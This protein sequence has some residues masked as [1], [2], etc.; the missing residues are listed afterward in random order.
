MTSQTAPFA[1]QVWD[2]A[3]DVGNSAPKIADVVMEASF[4]LTCDQARHEGA[5]KMLR[6]G[7]I[8]EV[9]RILRDRDDR[10]DQRDFGETIQQFA[11]LIQGLKS[12]SYFAPSAEEYVAVRDLIA[13][14]D[15]LNDARRFMR[16][17]GMECLAEADRLDALYAA[18]TG[19]TS[20]THLDIQGAA[21]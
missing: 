17:K 2:I 9:K 16:A 10:H 7:I 21:V 4:P 14:P 20:D 8:A 15:L 6:T 3:A 11:P 5:L 19:E 1:L 18:V 13:E 12:R